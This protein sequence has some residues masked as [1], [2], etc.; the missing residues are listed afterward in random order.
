MKPELG[1]AKAQGFIEGPEAGPVE[2]LTQEHP[3]LLEAYLHFR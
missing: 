1:A 2:I 3:T